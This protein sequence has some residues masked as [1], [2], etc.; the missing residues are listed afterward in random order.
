MAVTMLDSAK[1]GVHRKRTLSQLDRP[2][3]TQGKTNPIMW[4]TPE[5][6]MEVMPPRSPK[7]KT[8]CKTITLLI[9]N[10]EINALLFRSVHIPIRLYWW[11]F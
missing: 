9:V 10:K 2:S 3:F 8:K 6:F 7:F 4:K 5:A 11:L 1:R